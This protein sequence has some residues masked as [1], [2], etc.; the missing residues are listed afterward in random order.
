MLV[1]QHKDSPLA[2]QAIDFDGFQLRADI[3]QHVVGLFAP[4]VI[5]DFA[6]RMGDALGD[7]VRH[8]T[9]GEPGREPIVDVEHAA[10]AERERQPL[11]AV[12]ERAIGL[13]VLHLVRANLV[14][15]IV[16]DVTEVQR[17]E[18]AQAEIDRELQPCLARRRID[19]IVLLEEE[20]AEPVEAG[21]LHAEPVLR[22][23]H[24][25]PARSTRAG[26]EEHIVVDNILA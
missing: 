16:Q 8:D 22:L 23:V 17:V 3:L 18:R 7:T 2:P 11:H 6:G 20:D 24:P 15:D 4:E 19:P 5:D 26:R 21:V 13:A 12:L 9:R 14:A 25:K 1:E 10:I